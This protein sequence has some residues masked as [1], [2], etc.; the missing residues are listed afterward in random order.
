MHTW[1]LSQ[2]PQA[3]PVEKK[4]VNHME[5]ILHM[6]D[7]HIEKFY[8]WQIFMWKKILHIWNVNNICYVEKFCAQHMVYSRILHWFVEKSVVFVIY[9]VFLQ[10]R[11]W[12]D[13]RAFAWRKIEPNI[14]PVEKKG[15]ISGMWWCFIKIY[16]N[17]HH[18]AWCMGHT[19]NIWLFLTTLDICLQHLATSSNF[20]QLLPKFGSVC[21]LLAALP[22]L[23]TLGNIWQLLL[24]CFLHILSSCHLVILSS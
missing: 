22:F 17:L 18:W 8:I 21:Q 4:S 11:I 5:K 14:V 9:A 10:G 2:A 12:H 7:C 19:S 20:R 13:L 6:S 1:Y 23:T 15:Q 3:V 16:C 24:S